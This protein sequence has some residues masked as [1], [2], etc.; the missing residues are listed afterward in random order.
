M[1]V[2]SGSSS[3]YNSINRMFFSNAY[4]VIFV[5]DDRTCTICFTKT[6][7]MLKHRKNAFA[8]NVRGERTTKLKLNFLHCFVPSGRFGFF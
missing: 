5:K 7:N 1:L 2:I 3:K 8:E 4:Y 6:A